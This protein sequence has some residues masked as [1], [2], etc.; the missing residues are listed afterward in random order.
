MHGSE[1]VKNLSQEQFG[2]INKSK[3]QDIDILC[4]Q[5]N[6]NP[7]ITRNVAHQVGPSARTL[8]Q[9]L[10]KCAHGLDPMLVVESY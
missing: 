7:S 4:S 8:D 5:I 3:V 1:Q 2:T 10:P 9:F 6:C